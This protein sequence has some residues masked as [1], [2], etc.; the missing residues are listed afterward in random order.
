MNS[1]RTIRI[2]L[3]IVVAF[4]AAGAASLFYFQRTGDDRPIAMRGA[5]LD[6]EFN[7]VTEDGLAVTQTDFRDKPTAW[8]FG[9]TNC[10]DV[11]PTQLANMTR[12][13]EALGEDADLLN[14]VLVTVDPERDTP[15][16]LRN[17]MSVFD[18]RIIGLTGQLAEIEAFARGYYVYFQK[19]PLDAG[20]YTMDHTA[21][22]LVT[23]AQ[24]E[25]LSI[26]DPHEDPETQLA[27]LRRA[28]AG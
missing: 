16:V 9:F 20:G 18:P 13:L 26:L 25:L 12:N 19:V 22:V 17:Y 15:A 11:C 5:I 28:I 3:W 27:K 2:A 7:L 1:L 23:S 10:P 14:V 8:F 4:A 24:G 6:A 21:G